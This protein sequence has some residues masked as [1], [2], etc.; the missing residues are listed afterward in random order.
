MIMN[1]C[2]LQY[3]HSASFCTYLIFMTQVFGKQVSVHMDCVS[4][5][6]KSV[7]NCF[8]DVFSLA[9]LSSH[10]KLITLLIWKLM[11][12]TNCVIFLTVRVSACI[13]LPLLY[14]THVTNIPPQQYQRALLNCPL[15]SISRAKVYI[16]FVSL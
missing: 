10:L 3:L 4:Y 11:H 15:S 8:C 16:C 14:S 13:M 12:N 1:V 5:R 7:P 6:K 2:T 9:D